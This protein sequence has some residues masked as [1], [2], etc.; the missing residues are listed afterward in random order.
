MRRFLYL[1]SG[2]LVLIPTLAAGEQQHY[3]GVLAGLNFADLGTKTVEGGTAET[4][5]Q[6]LFG[7]GGVLGLWLRDNVY[8]HIEPKYLR[9]GG[10]LLEEDPI[11][12]LNFKFTF[13]EVP[14]LAKLVFGEKIRRYAFFGPTFGFL[15]TA[16]VESKY[17]PLLYKADVKGITKTV[18]FGL[19]LGTGF[20][21][22]LGKGSVFLDGRYAAGLT[23]LNKGG[24]VEF[25]SGD[26]V[27]VEEISPS[28]EIS[29]KGFQ[30]MLGYTFPI[31]GKQ[32]VTK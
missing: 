18:D 2:L 6:T 20:N 27:I 11:P 25:K 21:F 12:D 8:F 5:P 24:T 13:V 17:G 16:E 15:L 9:K 1:L 7:V 28:D 22:P 29:T 10:K 31:G 19:G 23:N 32:L 26:M 14:L 4:V 30:I 3:V